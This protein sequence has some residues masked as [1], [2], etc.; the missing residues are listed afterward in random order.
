MSAGKGAIVP[1]MTG[2]SSLSK[3]I[4]LA[5]MTNPIIG[6]IPA[7][8]IFNAACAA[9]FVAQF[10]LSTAD[11]LATGADSLQ[12]ECNEHRGL[13]LL[14]GCIGSALFFEIEGRG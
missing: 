11:A 5:K 4:I 10:H 3:Q 6:D 7:D 13:S 9:A 8:T 14:A 2:K 1:E 12:M